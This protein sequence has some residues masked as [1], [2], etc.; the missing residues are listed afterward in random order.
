MHVCMQEQMAAPFATAEAAA[1]QYPAEFHL[2][3]KKTDITEK[4]QLHTSNVDFVH[5]VLHTRCSTRQMHHTDS[6]STG[7]LLSR[8]F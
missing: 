7:L 2:I 6:A 1:E 8:P 5:V 3:H 4:V